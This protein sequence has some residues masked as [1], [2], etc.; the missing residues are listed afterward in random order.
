[1]YS[2]CQFLGCKSSC[3]SQFQATNVTP[4]AE[5]G[6]DAKDG[7]RQVSLPPSEAGPCPSQ[8]AALLVS[9]WDCVTLGRLLKLSEPPVSLL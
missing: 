9:A 6:R 4:K 5:L 7:F 8:S 2:F 3:H 1:M